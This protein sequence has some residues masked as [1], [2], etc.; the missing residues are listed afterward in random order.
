MISKPKVKYILFRMEKSNSR[1]KNIYCLYSDVYKQKITFTLSFHCI[2]KILKAKRLSLH[3][4]KKERIQI[5][6]LRFLTESILRCSFEDNILHTQI[7]LYMRNGI[8]NNQ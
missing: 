7:I 6:S 3:F 1:K 5:P 4:I 2:R 8:N